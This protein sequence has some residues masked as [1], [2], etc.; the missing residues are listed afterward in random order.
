[1]FLCQTGGINLFW[2]VI[3]L[4]HSRLT[5]VQCLFLFCVFDSVVFSEI[6]TKI[7]NIMHFVVNNTP[8]SPSVCVLISHAAKLHTNRLVCIYKMYFWGGCVANCLCY[9]NEIEA[10]PRFYLFDLL[11]IILWNCLVYFL[12]VDVIIK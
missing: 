11:W 9:H 2:V 10:G 8:S 12:E 7:V 1:M 3:D 5:A 6:F 4:A